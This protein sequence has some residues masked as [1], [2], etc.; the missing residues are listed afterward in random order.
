MHSI[1]TFL[2]PRS[3]FSPIFTSGKMKGMTPFI[4]TV[5]DRLV[6]AFGEEAKSGEPIDLKEKFGKFSM[7]TIA[8]C[9]FGVD[10]QSF[11][12]TESQFVKN[13]KAV[14]RYGIAIILGM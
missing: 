8:S 1:N 4:D 2:L 11:T 13:A 7:D 12:N 3:T 10:A 6:A 5:A 9:A 14:F